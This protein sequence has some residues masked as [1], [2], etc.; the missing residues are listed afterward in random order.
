VTA[1]PGEAGALMIRLQA[2]RGV[3]RVTRLDV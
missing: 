3:E 2:Q 1:P